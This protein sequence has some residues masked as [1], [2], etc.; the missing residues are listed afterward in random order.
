MVAISDPHRLAVKTGFVDLN[1]QVVLFDVAQLDMARAITQIERRT[2]LKRRL[3]KRLSDADFDRKKARLAKSHLAKNVDSQA[4]RVVN[5]HAAA[6]VGSLV[7][8][9]NSEARVEVIHRRRF[10]DVFKMDGRFRHLERAGSCRQNEGNLA[11][12][13]AKKRKRTGDQHGR[14]A[15]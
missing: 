4:V 13:L 11:F 8:A 15:G 6:Q 12:G 3:A 7:A 1:E 9:V 10:I 5:F 2:D 14:K